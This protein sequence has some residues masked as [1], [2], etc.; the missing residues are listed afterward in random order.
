MPA[1]LNRQI[2]YIFTPPSAGWF[3]QDIHTHNGTKIIRYYL[4]LE[5][6]KS[7]RKDQ[8]TTDQ[9]QCPPEERDAI[10]AKVM[11]QFKLDNEVD[12]LM[13]KDAR[14]LLEKLHDE[15]ENNISKNKPI[16][17]VA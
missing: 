4:G 14:E 1:F 12:L 13:N 5:Q 15:R 17:R 7:F 8:C 6:V 10:T 11:Q 16:S 3:K 2:H 9:N